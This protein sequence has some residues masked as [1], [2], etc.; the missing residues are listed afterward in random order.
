M[1][2]ELVRLNHVEWFRR[3]QLW[4]ENNFSEPI[5]LEFNEDSVDMPSIIYTAQTED[6]FAPELTKAA[7]SAAGTQLG[8]AVNLVASGRVLT[9][10]VMKPCAS[11]AALLLETFKWRSLAAVRRVWPR[12]LALLLLLL[13]I[14]LVC[15]SASA[16]HAH[17]KDWDSPY[18][19]MFHS[20]FGVAIW[21]GDKITGSVSVSHEV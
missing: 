20:M 2:S 16:L 7:R 14:A 11:D 12:S 5:E 6:G 13:S 9:I 18:E 21:I 19:T 1:T 10:S 17:W 8:P 3:I 4:L 15:Y